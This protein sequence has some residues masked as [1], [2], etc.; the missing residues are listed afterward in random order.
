[1]RPELLGA[2]AGLGVMPRL[3]M[4]P[5]SEVMLRLAV[6]LGL[7]VRTA[8]A[9]QRVTVLRVMRTA[10]ARQRVT[11]LRV[12]RTAATRQ[13]VTV[14]RVMRTA[15]TRQRV[16]VSPVIHGRHR[17]CAPDCSERCRD[18]RKVLDAPHCRSLFRS[19]PSTLNVAIVCDTQLRLDRALDRAPRQIWSLVDIRR[20]ASRTQRR[21]SSATY[22]ELGN[23]GVG[24]R[25]GGNRGAT[26]AA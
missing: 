7:V 23:I 25:H 26:A 20:R 13:R 10:A 19:S 9:R 5:Q 1:M 3:G 18:C 6:M 2:T 15:A 24:S 4:M 11:V 16:T 21:I 12:M 8:A 22:D 14:L 17:G